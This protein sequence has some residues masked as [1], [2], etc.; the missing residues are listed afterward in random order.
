MNPSRRKFIKNSAKALPL[1]LINNNIYGNYIQENNLKIALQVYSLASQL[2]RR[3]FDLHEFP[4]IVK[5]T[6]GLDGAEY[7]SLSLA[8]KENDKVYLI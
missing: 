5:N 2:M 4:G 8:Q 1:A 7:W 6:Y 3:E